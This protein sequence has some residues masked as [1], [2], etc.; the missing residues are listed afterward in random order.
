MGLKVLVL[1]NFEV[2]LWTLVCDGLRGMYF[3]DLEID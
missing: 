1:R 3:V 2:G